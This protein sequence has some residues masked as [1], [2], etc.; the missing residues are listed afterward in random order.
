[1]GSSRAK[2]LWSAAAFCFSGFPWIEL[3]WSGA[4]MHKWSDL[5][6]VLMQDEKTVSQMKC[7]ATGLTQW[8]FVCRNLINIWQMSWQSHTSITTK[9]SI[10]KK[11]LC[12]R[13]CS[14]SLK[15]NMGIIFFDLRH[16]EGCYRPKTSLRC[17]KWAERL[18]FPGLLIPRLLFLDCCSWTFVLLQVEI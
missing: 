17:Q 7:I 1:M 14:K 6:L 18:S 16:H 4:S 11:T 12:H 15:F 9:P 3:I 10:L 13:I 5:N 8:L 2:L